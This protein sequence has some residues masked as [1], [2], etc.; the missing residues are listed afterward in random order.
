MCLLFIAHNAHPHYRLVIA[1]N[2][3]EFYDR[4]TKPAAFWEETPDLLAGRDLKAGGTWLGIT[5]TGKIA[6][7][8]NYRQPHL[9]KGQAP[10]RGKLVSNFLEGNKDVDA[11]LDYLTMNG[12]R[13][14]GHNLI[15]GDNKRLCWYSNRGGQNHNLSPGLYGLSNHLL[16]TPWPKVIRVKEAMER[17]LSERDV[18]DS[19]EI[20]SI[21]RDRRLADDTSLPDTGIGFE[22]ERVLSPIFIVSPGYGTRSSTIVSIDREDRVIFME[23]TYNEDPGHATTVTYEFQ[24]ES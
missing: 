14:N 16:D 6:A 19:E 12:N 18:L 7:I 1:A 3:D 11:Y 8:T 10:S 4:P 13:Y 24:I 20:F 15:L 23:R 22:R 17:L 5:R 9:E 2:R 21:L